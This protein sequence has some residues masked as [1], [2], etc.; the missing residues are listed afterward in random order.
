MVPSLRVG[1]PQRVSPGDQRS[2]LCSTS[3]ALQALSCGLQVS[4]LWENLLISS[5]TDTVGGS[6][7]PDLSH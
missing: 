6:E 2:A 4:V 7:A 1:A 5:Q 3:S